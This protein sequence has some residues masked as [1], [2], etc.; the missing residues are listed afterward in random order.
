MSTESIAHLFENAIKKGWSYSLP[1]IVRF[2]VDQKSPNDGSAIESFTGTQEQ[3]K[4]PLFRGP[5]ATDEPIEVQVYEA[6]VE[7]S[8]CMAEFAAVRE[9]CQAFGDRRQC[10]APRR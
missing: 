8:R 3:P 5:I 9:S 2:V 6:A 7:R 4:H 10:R 1:A